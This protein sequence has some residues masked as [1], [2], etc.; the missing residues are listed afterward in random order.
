M[1]ILL[2]VHQFFP[3]FAAGTE[4]LTY[5]VARELREHGHTVRILTGH[6]GL[7]ELPD[8]DRCD[9]YEFDAFHIYRFH[10]AYT[11]MAGQTSKIAVGYDNRL[12]AAYFERILL[13]FQPDVVHFFHLNRLGTGL[14]EGAVR[15]GIPSFMTPTDF[16]TI[17]PTAQM[18]YGDGGL[19]A[20]P[21]PLSG[22]CV[23]HFA[24]STQGRW[25]RLLVS[26]LP[27]AVADCLVKLSQ[28]G[29][30]SA[31]PKR[32]EVLAITSRLGVNIARLNQLS[33]LVVSNEFMKELLIRYGVSS[34][35]I[36]QTAYGIDIEQNDDI[37]PRTVLRRP[38]R[39]GFIGTLAEH[40]GCHVLIAAFKALPPGEA[41]LRIYGNPE[42][43]PVYT[44]RLKQ[45]ARHSQA[46]EFCGTFHNSEIGE[47][48]ADLDVLVA[49]SLWYENTPL[50]VYSAQ[51]AHCPVLGSDLP[52]ISTVIGNEVNGLLFKA[53]D[54]SA[55]ARQL[56]RFIH[57]PG[58]AAR[59]S[60]HARQPK[61]TVFY[62]TELLKIWAVGKT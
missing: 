61:S 53:G 62:V 2:T 14:I 44:R 56:A 3:Q 28:S 9:E 15:A 34:H 5:S 18:V 23:K 22:N 36:T 17:C 47:V 59:L 27:T 48:L 46:I 54:A 39:I 12:A 55:L 16:W 7:A 40:K 32:E 41:V 50:V 19:C 38:V 29:V 31:Y 6:P 13:D 26:Y 11:S 33:G 51:A 52:G 1:K 57:E 60:S 25:M 43:L 30:L 42:E 24:Q 20:G 35:L 10:H 49:P 4:I 58:L 21:N 37:E 8:E 45:L